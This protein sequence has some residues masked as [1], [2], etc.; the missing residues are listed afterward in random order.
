MNEK[1]CSGFGRYHTDNPENPKAMPFLGISYAGIVVMA[2]NPSTTRKQ[3]A[4]WIIAST[5]LSRSKSDQMERGEFYCLVVDLDHNPPN[6]NK[7]AEIVALTCLGGD[8]LI[9]TSRSATQNFQKSHVLIPTN[10]VRL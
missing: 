7:I 4:Q 8:F 2:S 5:L 6:I 9:Y 1:L 10:K 3:Y